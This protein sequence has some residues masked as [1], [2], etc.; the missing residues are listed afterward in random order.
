MTLRFRG[1]DLRADLRDVRR[2]DD[3]VN[4]DPRQAAA[5]HRAGYDPNPRYRPVGAAVG[6]GWIYPFAAIPATA[7]VLA[8]EGPT[9]LDW[10]AATSGIA[11]AARQLGRQIEFVDVRAH[12]VSWTEVLARTASTDL[13]DDRDFARLA[14]GSVASLFETLPK[15]QPEP[16]RLTVVWGPGAGLVEHDILWYVDLPKRFAEAAV[17]AGTGVNLGQAPHSGRGTTKRLFFV[18]WPLLDAWRMELADEINWWI[19]TQNPGQPTSIDGDTLRDTLAYLARG[20]F[21]TRPTF[22]TASWGGHWAQSAL[23]VNPEARNTGLGYELIAPESGVLIG[24]D[25]E[26]QVEVP[27]ELM[28]AL[29]P[30]EVLGGKVC[31]QFGSSFPIRFDYLDTVGGGNLSIHC[32]PQ[33]DYMRRVFG[34]PY[35]QHESYYVMVTRPGRGIFLGLRDGV[36]LDTFE[37]QAHDAETDGDA[38]DIERYVMRLPA[39]EHQLFMIP[40]GTPHGSG[41]GNVVLEISATPYLYS[42]RF[43]DWLRRDED[44]STRPVH[45]NHAFANLD[46]RSGHSVISDLVQAPWT[47][48]EGAGWAEE[49]IGALPEVFF[50]V[51]RLVI[52][53]NAPVAAVTGDRFHVLNLVEGE[54]ALLVTE[55]GR[56]HALAYAETMLVPAAAG[57]YT[58]QR[59]GT[60]RVRIVKAL[61][62]G[63]SE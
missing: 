33:A 6:A 1:D 59:K 44:G 50:E 3:I 62:R 35:T 21:R 2:S 14:R 12:M 47:V 27:L 8:V 32:H 17:A 61:V 41:E 51:R 13:P 26:H 4:Q 34:W 20:P 40:A 31:E 28:V 24:E 56:T 52:D 25:P 43:Y 60:Q 29:S 30:N 39:T 19:D 5:P 46:P 48:E 57:R 38:F 37:R 11:A 55:S 49:R 53:T 15:P 63:A 23:G 36:D 10:D 42:L 16:G 58:I 7:Q 45:V 18:D 54:G 22:S 9:I